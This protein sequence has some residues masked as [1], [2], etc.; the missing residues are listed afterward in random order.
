[1]FIV[2]VGGETIR[3][4][5]KNFPSDGNNWIALVKRGGVVD[6]GQGRLDYTDYLSGRV[7]HLKSL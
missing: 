2:C 6:A 5:Y 7:A 3:V 4:Q 1:M